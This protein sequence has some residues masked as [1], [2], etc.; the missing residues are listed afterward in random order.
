MRDYKNAKKYIPKMIQNVLTRNWTKSIDLIQQK[1]ETW[2][3][4]FRGTQVIDQQGPNV[5]NP[6]CVNPQIGS[7]VNEATF[8]DDKITQRPT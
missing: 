6:S 8:Q 4:P 3:L 2:P 7:I 1:Q 5:G